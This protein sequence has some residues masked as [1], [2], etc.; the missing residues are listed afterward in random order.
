MVRVEANDETLIAKALDL[1]AQSV[2]I[3][4]V[5]SAEEAR[6]A[7]RGARYAPLGARGIGGPRQGLGVSDYWRKADQ[8]IMVGVMIEDLEGLSALDAIATVDGVNFIFLAPFDLAQSMGHLGEPFHP[9]V[10]DAVRRAIKRVTALGRAAGTFVTDEVVEEYLT[11]GARLL[12]FAPIVY[13]YQGATRFRAAVNARMQ[14][15]Q[16]PNSAN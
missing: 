4:H 16:A 15:L 3:P 10:Q 6:R 8:E 1:G 13:L 9:A 12:F 2:V 14:A 11:L 5:C 7:V